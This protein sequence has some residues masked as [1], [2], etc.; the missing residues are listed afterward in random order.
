MIIYTPCFAR[1]LPSSHFPTFYTI[2][3]IVHFM[4]LFPSSLLPLQVVGCHSCFLIFAFGLWSISPFARN[5]V[6][7]VSFIRKVLYWCYSF[8]LSVTMCDS[9]HHMVRLTLCVVHTILAVSIKIWCLSLCRCRRVF[10]N[11]SYQDPFEAFL[12]NGANVCRL[13]TFS[14]LIYSFAGFFHQCCILQAR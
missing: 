2:V 10:I 8:N 4:Q 13:P 6:C 1:S 3:L 9:Y 14:L 7:T 11:F 12:N 5:F